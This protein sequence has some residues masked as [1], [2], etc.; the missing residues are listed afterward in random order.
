MKQNE[1]SKRQKNSP[2]LKITG[3]TKRF[4][5]VCAIMD[6]SLD[7]YRGEVLALVG[8][9][10]AGK[11]TLIKILS[12]VYIPDEGSIY[13]CGNKVSFTSPMDA[14]RLGI[15][16][17]YQNLALMD[18]LD[19]SSNIFM[20]R[21][22]R[23]K[24]FLGSLGLLNIKEMRGCAS[25]LLNNFN[26]SLRSVD[27]QVANLSGGQ[28]QIV[29]LCRAVYFNAQVILMDEPTA[30][31]G[32]AETQKVYEF[33]NEVRKRGIAVVIVSHNINEVFNVAD[34]FAVLKT[35]RLV[36]VIEKDETSVDNIVSM[37]IS[38]KVNNNL[39]GSSPI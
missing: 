6:I 33:I 5:G 4:G 34:R 39:T 13:F 27:E 36:T 18:N 11:S 31:L 29:S 17:I 20:G 23:A 25:R 32:V 30:A 28:R 9:N 15:E 26:I 16:T 12:G 1:L 22:V 14:R 19:I 21:E 37:I 3:V 38:G 10:G 2:I 7:I 35:G 8:D 24:G